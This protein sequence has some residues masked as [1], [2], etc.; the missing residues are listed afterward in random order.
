MKFAIATI[1]TLFLAS[2][3]AENRRVLKGASHEGKQMKKKGSKKMTEKGSLAGSY[4]APYKFYSFSN[5]QFFDSAYYQKFT[6]T[7]EPDVY[8]WA[9][10]YSTDGGQTFDGTALGTAVVT[11]MSKKEMTF[12]V[13][14]QEDVSDIEDGFA[15]EGTKSGNSLRQ[16]LIGFFDANTFVS[17]PEPTDV[18][19]GD[20]ACPL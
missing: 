20:D 13:M 12:R 8:L 11:S 3:N 19:L 15:F 9:E 5:R 18:E 6:S 2:A 1:A 16:V 7:D 4:F 14:N 10:C 17:Y